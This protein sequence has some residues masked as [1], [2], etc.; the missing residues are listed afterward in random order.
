[1]AIIFFFLH[2]GYTPE[3]DNIII[4]TVWV[5]ISNWNLFMFNNS[6]FKISL[7]LSI[8][9]GLKSSKSAVWLIEEK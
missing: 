9:N 3:F 5:Y 8:L 4:F 6:D 2:C 7:R 1:M